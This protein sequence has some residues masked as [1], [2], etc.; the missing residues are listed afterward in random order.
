MSCYVVLR[1]N[2]RHFGRNCWLNSRR[3]RLL[4]QSKHLYDSTR[5]HGVIPEKPLDLLFT[6]VST[7]LVICKLVQCGKKRMAV[8]LQGCVHIPALAV[9]LLHHYNSLIRRSLEKNVGN[10]CWCFLYDIL[11]PCCNKFHSC[12]PETKSTDWIF[13]TFESLTISLSSDCDIRWGTVSSGKSGSTLQHEGPV[14]L[15]ERCWSVLRHA[16]STV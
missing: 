13:E 7:A 14:R 11:T 3:W 10:D 8:V 1:N 5:L 6:A 9:V 4:L 15:L 2:Y 16:E 12:T